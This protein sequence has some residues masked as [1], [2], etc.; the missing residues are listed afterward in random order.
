M[1]TYVVRVKRYLGPV[2]LHFIKESWA[3]RSEGEE[4][5]LSIS[6]IILQL[7]EAH[8][9]CTACYCLVYMDRLTWGVYMFI[10]YGVQRGGAGP[11]PITG[12]ECVVVS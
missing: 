5:Y 1:F 2:Q 12:G 4:I 6:F 8:I 10:S 11:G 3:L 7:T 9:N